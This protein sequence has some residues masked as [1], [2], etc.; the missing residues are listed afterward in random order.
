M[1]AK[2]VS[3]SK[4][5]DGKRDYIAYQID[6]KLRDLNWSV[7]KRYSE[8]HAFHTRLSS[9]L[10]T[11]DVRI[12]FPPKLFGKSRNFDTVQIEK[13]LA[14]LQ[15]W[16][17]HITTANSIW[18]T[19]YEAL[20][21][22]FLETRKNLAVIVSQ[23][24]KVSVDLAAEKLSQFDTFLCG[25]PDW[26]QAIESILNEKT[27]LI[28]KLSGEDYHKSRKSLCENGNL[29]ENATKYL[30]DI[31]VIMA[32]RGLTDRSEAVNLYYRN[33]MNLEA[34]L[35]S[36]TSVDPYAFFNSRAPLTS[37]VGVLEEQK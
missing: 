4:E 6:C 19:N 15:S 29:V 5:N 3:Y 27:H 30:K 1:T 8:C 26:N 28:M 25:L 24:C 12:E 7:K 22:E 10:V 23:R 2:I 9:T 36:T 33:K 14:G 35:M 37:D 11:R 31:Q 20:I 21:L 34:C 16:F 17:D 32:R 13:R 18:F